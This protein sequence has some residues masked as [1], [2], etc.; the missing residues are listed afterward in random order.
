MTTNRM[1]LLICG[2]GLLGACSEE[3]PRSVL[4]LMENPI[5]L[6]ATVVRCSQNRSE[7]RYE[8]ECVNAREAVSRVM[9]KE[10]QAGRAALE[11]QSDRKRQ[12]LRRT[13]EAAAEARRRTADAQRR[14]EEAE[15]LAQF[16]ASP[17]TDEGDPS[18]TDAAT[19]APVAVVPEA[20]DDTVS[21]GASTGSLPA[22]DGGNAPG[23]DTSP[24]TDLEDIREELRRRGEEAG[25][26]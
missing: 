23:V 9:A 15:Y 8:A 2:I 13:Q 6:E 5:L 12:A 19:N 24:P 26:E 17:P 14:R 22:P 11:A 16:G 3:P 20:V 10:E 1:S 21:N 4:E 18:A 25:T 7:S